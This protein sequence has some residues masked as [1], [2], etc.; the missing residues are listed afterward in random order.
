MMAL[1]SNDAAIISNEHYEF[2]QLNQVGRLS[3]RASKVVDAD[4]QSLRQF[5]AE[6]LQKVGDYRKR[7]LE[8]SASENELKTK[9]AQQTKAAADKERCSTAKFQTEVEL[10]KKKLSDAERTIAESNEDWTKR[11]S[12]LTDENWAHGLENENLKRIETDLEQQVARFQEAVETAHEREEQMAAA[13][14]ALRIEYANIDRCYTESNG[15]LV[16]LQA[17]IRERFKQHDVELQDL[18]NYLTEKAAQE[19]A[20]I[21]DENAKLKEALGVRE[22]RLD[23]DKTALQTW[24]EQLSYLDQHLKQYSEK[25]KKSKFEMIRLTKNIEGE[26]TFS[27]THPFTDYLEMADLEIAQITQQLAG[28]SSMSPLKTKLELR[29]QNAN[30]HRD[31]IKVILDKS[32]TQLSDHAKAVQLLVKSLEFLT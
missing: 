8:L 10:L 5:N 25:L 26:I 21:R 20:V 24:K 19:S 29:L 32:V 12:K 2:L 11:L 31:G 4:E 28:L 23:Q 18:T 16:K 3:D 9:I 17:E 7:N 1:M 22:T 14:E 15:T 27:V 13:Y 6:L 30:A